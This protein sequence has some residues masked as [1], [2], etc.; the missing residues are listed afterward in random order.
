MT[1]AATGTIERWLDRLGLHRKELRA[2]ALYDWANSAFAT[3][4]MA[5]VLPIY[6]ARVAAGEL[7]GNVATAYWGYTVSISVL[8]VVA[9]AP[10]LG[11]IADRAGARK[12]FL[13]AFLVLG[14]SGTAA[15]YLVG[16]G[17][18]LLASVV[19]ILANVGFNGANVFYDA[20]LPDIATPDEVDRIS[21]GGWAIGYL[22]G[23][24][25]LLVNLI[26][27][28]RPELFGF[29]DAGVASRWTFV[30]VAVWWA[31]FSIPLL[32][33]VPETRP[34]RTETEG[35]DGVGHIRAAFGRLAET[36]RAAR[37][38]PDTFKFLIAFWL[39]VDGIETIIK[40]AT[41]YGTEIGIGQGDLIGA[42]LL[43]QFIGIPFTFLFGGLAGRFGPKNGIYIALAAYTGITILG[44]FMQEP[45]HFWALAGAVGVVQGGAQALSRSLFATLIPQ[46][47][48][49]EFFSFYSVFKKSAGIVGPAL[50][51]IVA[52]IS[53]TSRLGILSLIAF[54]VGGMI[55]LSRVDVEKGRRAARE[56]GN[57]A[58]PAV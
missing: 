32:R 54:F 39:Y 52:Q 36:F 47:R 9:L 42:L 5:A 28:E 29:A 20:L 55:L 22:G 1:N 24:L 50:F 51:G 13:G 21:T 43:V 6:Y 49:A 40:M 57:E 16:S 15:L 33:N 38:Y 37:R 31:V 45:W 8:L 19:F 18:W 44:Y 27:I 17:D 58:A 46:G 14:V 34:Q 11:A 23:G 56:A 3:T 7:P 10:V 48:A 25:L 26:M 12:R 4:I 35:D 41:I 2:W 53:G 30:S